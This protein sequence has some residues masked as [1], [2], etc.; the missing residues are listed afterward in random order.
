MP[1]KK[2][3]AAKKGSA[4]SGSLA[5]NMTRA[6]EDA[7]MALFTDPTTSPFRLGGG[8]AN[9][10]RPVRPL[11]LVEPSATPMQFCIRA[12]LVGATPPLWRRLTLPSNLTLDRVHQVLQAAFGWT[13]SHLHQFSLE[14]GRSLPRMQQIL[15]AFDVA[16]GA[17]GVPET[18][19]RL[20]Q[21]LGKKDDKLRYTYD[22]GDGWEHL[23]KLE[24]VEPRQ[25]TD[26]SVRC[27]AGRRQGAPEDVG[28]IYSY[29]NLLA[30]AADPQ[31]PDL[32]DLADLIDDLELWDFDD[33]IDLVGI[34]LSL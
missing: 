7:I 33:R 10:A 13:D 8:F 20:D 3:T 6:Q 19:L 34:N 29:D 28:G 21:V 23:L 2:K 5:G 16:D 24:A 1:K 18:E 14:F 17:D 9:G 32:E 12:D 30:V 25:A 15:S 27:I 11:P 22:F 26:A 31:H 4:R